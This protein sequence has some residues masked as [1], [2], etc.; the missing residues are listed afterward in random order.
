MTEP[1]ET[2][3]LELAV[4]YALHAVSNAERDEIEDRLAQ[5]ARPEAD[6]F[7]DEVRAVRE[8]MAVVSAVSASEPPA[9]LRRRLLS[10]V[11][12]DNVRSL[13]VAQPDSTGN[14]WRGPV[15]AV[16]AALVIGLGAVG[17]GIALRPAPAK[18]STAQQVFGAPDV[19]TVSGAI[20]G[21]GTATV[22]FSREKNAGV[23]VMNDVPKPAPGTVYQMWLVGNSG[24]TSAGTMDDNAVTPSTTAVLPDL[25][26]STALKFTVEP[27]TGSTQPTGQVVAELPL[28]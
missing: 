1:H 18:V 20:P 12:D 24:A 3:L 4:P 13:P 8:T 6:A 23:L 19:H 17:L 9:D 2:D 7:Y 27:G 5:L 10:A 14:R 25:G 15:L 21:G 28:V 16:A 11:A 26:G 22:V